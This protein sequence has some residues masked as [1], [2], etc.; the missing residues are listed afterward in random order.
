MDI[1]QRIIGKIGNVVVEV[2]GFFTERFINLCK[3]NNISISNVKKITSGLIRFSIN[4]SEFKKIKPFAKK[5]KCKIKIK[6]KEGIYFTLFKYRK[7]KYLI[8]ILIILV[9]LVVSSNSFVWKINTNIELTN[10]IEHRLE[11]LN[12]KKGKLL[13][14]IDKN[15]IIKKLRAEFKE[16]SWIGIDIEG[17]HVNIEFKEKT[18]L[19]DKD[20]QE[21]RIGDI[22][23]DKSGILTKV[24]VE[25]GTAIYKIG[26]FIQ[27]G[28]KLVEGKIFS[29]YIG[30]INTTAKGILRIKSEYIFEKEYKYLNIEKE[31]KKKSYNLG[32]SIDSK[33]FY[34]DYLNSNKKYDKIKQS[35]KFNFFSKQITLDYYI[36]NKY[37]EVNVV[38]EYEKLLEKF[39]KDSSEYINEIINELDTPKIINEKIEEIKYDDKVIFK[40]IYLIDERIGVFKER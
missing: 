4:I 35:I 37:L 3:I 40:K 11:K 16:Y 34:I 12:I 30:E 36:F 6:K 18:I 19:K 1:K 2:E 25:K 5:T 7:R 27:E 28:M 26:S 13:I 10:E 8:G 24:V 9:I 15:E 20:I 39:N 14:N 17:G 33:E 31:Y 38:Y 22:Y 29:K 21:T 32:F 23:A